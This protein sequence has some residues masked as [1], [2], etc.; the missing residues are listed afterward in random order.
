MRYSYYNS[1]SVIVTSENLIIGMAD[2][3]YK[4]RICKFTHDPIVFTDWCKHT[5][6]NYGRA[7]GIDLDVTSSYLYTGGYIDHGNSDKTALIM[8]I[9]YSDGSDGILIGLF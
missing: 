2:D 4:Y 9:D 6:S 3:S 1:D 7:F 5:N 8:S